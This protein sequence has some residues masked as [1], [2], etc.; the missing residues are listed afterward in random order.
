[1]TALLRWP[2]QPR[3]ALGVAAALAAGG[4]EPGTAATGEVVAQTRLRVCADPG[5]LPYSN[6]KGEG[7]E[8]KIAELIASDLGVPLEYTWFPQT[9]G[10]VR[11][12]H[13][14]QRGDLTLGRTEERRVGKER[15]GTGIV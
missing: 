11:N 1:M 8:N 14:A 6:D 5:N 2:L 7:F 15:R 10:F 12:T 9:I 3:G 13:A 4:A